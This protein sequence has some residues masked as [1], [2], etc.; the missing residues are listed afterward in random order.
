MSGVIIASL[1]G[2]F[3]KNDK[4]DQWIRLEGK[5]SQIAICY[6]RIDIENLKTYGNGLWQMKI[7]RR[8]LRY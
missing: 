4:L 1:G 7:P 2:L 6:F 5:I 8:M 3:Y